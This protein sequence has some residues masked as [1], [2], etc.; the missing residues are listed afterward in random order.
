MNKLNEFKALCKKERPALPAPSPTL[1]R[2][3]LL[4]LTFYFILKYSRLTMLWQLQ[5][6]FSHTYTCI[7]FPPT[8]LLSRLPINI[9]QRSLCYTWGPWTRGSWHLRSSK[10]SWVLKTI[11]PSALTLV[12]PCFFLLKFFL[13]LKNHLRCVLFLKPSLDS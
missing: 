9:E 2:D 10:A 4:F 6:H 7:H 12:L 3:S 8:P 13:C 5:V 1:T 11:L